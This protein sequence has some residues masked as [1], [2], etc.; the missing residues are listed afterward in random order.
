MAVFACVLGKEENT[1][2]EKKNVLWFDMKEE[3]ER[4]KSCRNILGQ[5]SGYVVDH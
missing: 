2:M 5:I 1:Q 4:N 3:S